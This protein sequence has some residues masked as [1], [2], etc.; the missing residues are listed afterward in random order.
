MTFERA[1]R[2]FEDLPTEEQW[3]EII[4]SIPGEKVLEKIENILTLLFGPY[5]GF[6]RDESK[7]IYPLIH[8]WVQKKSIVTSTKKK[9]KRGKPLAHRLT[10]G[11]YSKW[12]RD[13]PHR[14]IQTG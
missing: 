8:F 14:F 7:E 3:T 10:I 9:D 6:E 4:D 11:Q 13:P 12:D 2:W 5:H 1:Q